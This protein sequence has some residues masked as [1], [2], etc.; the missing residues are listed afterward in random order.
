[1]LP[2]PRAWDSWQRVLN[3]P[4]RD[5]VAMVEEE[6]EAE[7]MDEDEDLDEEDLPLALRALQPAS[8]VPW[9][10]LRAQQECRLSASHPRAEWW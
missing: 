9:C 2:Q 1:M 4:L 6:E 5:L 8:G 10:G 3:A 7:N